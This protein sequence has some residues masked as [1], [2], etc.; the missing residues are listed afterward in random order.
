MGHLHQTGS[1]SIRPKD[2]FGERTAYLGAPSRRD[3]REG[4]V[5]IRGLGVVS[6]RRLPKRL[7]VSVGSKG[8]AEEEEEEE[9]GRVPGN[10]PFLSLSPAFFLTLRQADRMPRVLLA[11]D[12]VCRL[13]FDHWLAH[14]FEELFIIIHLVS[15]SALRGGG[16]ICLVSVPPREKV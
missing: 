5:W 3:W 10:V 7:S 13:A 16:V 15:F 8:D 4:S 12:N 11:Q 14:F 1:P 6:P 9:E 2:Q